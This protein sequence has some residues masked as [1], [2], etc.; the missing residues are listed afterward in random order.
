[1]HMVVNGDAAY[2]V[3]SGSNVAGFGDSDSDTV[4]VVSSRDMLCPHPCR[5]EEGQLW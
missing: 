4:V 2:E 3:V 5:Q 1:V